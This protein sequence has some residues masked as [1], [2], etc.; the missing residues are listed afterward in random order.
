MMRNVYGT[1]WGHFPELNEVVSV[2]KDN[3]AKQKRVHVGCI[4]N[5]GDYTSRQKT[6]NQNR[7]GE[8][9]ADMDVFVSGRWRK[10]VKLLYYLQYR[11][12]VY[13]LVKFTDYGE[14]DMYSAERVQGDNVLQDKTLEVKEGYYD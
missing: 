14:Y 10:D 12:M 13:R 11:D 2:W 5:K 3:P 9:S 4:P 1:F 8:I 6:S 7:V